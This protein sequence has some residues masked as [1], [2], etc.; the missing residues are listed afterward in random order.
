M[1]DISVDIDVDKND[2]DKSDIDKNNVDKIITFD[3]KPHNGDK[4]DIDKSDIDKNN[5]DKIFTFDDYKPHEGKPIT[6]MEV[7]PEGN[8]LVTYSKDDLSFVGWNI[9]DLDEGQIKLDNTIL[10]E[11]IRN[12]NINVDSLCVSDD[13]KLV[14]TYS[15]NNHSDRNYDGK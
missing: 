2:I 1:S 12:D 10:I 7:S 5:V 13:K 4:N 15:Y 6:N 8:Y 14:C 3:D 9:E 11:R